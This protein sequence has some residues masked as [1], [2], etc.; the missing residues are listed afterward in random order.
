MP[1]HVAL[2]RVAAL[3]ASKCSSQK[4]L[5]SAACFCWVSNA[6]H[7]YCIQYTHKHKKQLKDAR[8]NKVRARA[9]NTCTRQKLKAYFDLICLCYSSWK[10]L[11]SR[12]HIISA[13]GDDWSWI[14]SLFIFISS[15][16]IV[17]FCLHS[18]YNGPL[19]W[20]VSSMNCSLCSSPPSN[21]T[22]FWRMGD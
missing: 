10:R 16:S 4:A 13:W 3:A 5:K 20:P 21:F 2:Q 18:T 8:T 7:P 15:N 17:I 1:L 12:Q 9:S 22:V 11:C 6:H 14:S 19:R